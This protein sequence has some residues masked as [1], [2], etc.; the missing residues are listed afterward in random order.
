[1]LRPWFGPEVMQR[2]RE[3]AVRAEATRRRRQ[4]PAEETAAPL[5]GEQVIAEAEVILGSVEAN[6]SKA[7]CDEVAGAA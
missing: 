4:R 6:G 7:C 2:E 1:M 5:M 3:L